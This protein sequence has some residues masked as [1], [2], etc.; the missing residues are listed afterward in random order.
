MIYYNGLEAII[1]A[2]YLEDYIVF[3]LGKSDIEVNPLGGVNYIVG[4]TVILTKEGYP[5]DLLETLLANSNQVYSRV[6]GYGEGVTV[7]PYLMR[8]N[9]K[10]MWNGESYKCP[11]EIGTNDS[12]F[13]DW[14]GKLNSC[15]INEDPETG[16]PCLYFPKIEGIQSP[17]LMD[18]ERNLTA[19]G[20]I[21]HQVGI[22][23]C[24]RFRDMDLLKTKKI[25]Q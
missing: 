1:E 22:N 7:Y 20:W 2:I 21:L 19:L 10:A 15:S 14:L 16:K 23:L 18:K 25:L 12:Q 24:P 9:F 4:K 13:W 17:L 3:K 6:Q 5:Q 11:D 8:P